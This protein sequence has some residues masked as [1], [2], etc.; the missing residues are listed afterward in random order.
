MNEDPAIGVLH[1]M[2]EMGAKDNPKTGQIGKVIEPPPNLRV[3]L[4]D[5]IIDKEDIWINENLLIGYRREAKGVIKSGT[6]SASCAVGAPHAHQ[7]NNEYTND[8]IY[9]DTL[10]AGDHVFI[11]PLLGSQVYY[12]SGKAVKL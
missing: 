8:I 4:N 10:K 6:Q 3:K 12:V 1:M 7:I 5:I 2:R 9:T 11:Y